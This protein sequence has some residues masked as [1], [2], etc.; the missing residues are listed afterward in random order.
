M[1]LKV[2]TPY[3]HMRTLASLFHFFFSSYLDASLDLGLDVAIRVIRRCL[4]VCSGLPIE[5]NNLSRQDL[6]HL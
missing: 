5:E 2:A 3:F 1:V 6:L 4:E